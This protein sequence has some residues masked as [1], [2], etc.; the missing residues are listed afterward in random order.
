MRSFVKLRS[1]SRNISGGSDNSGT[2][3]C[4]S[5]SMMRRSTDDDGY[6]LDDDVDDGEQGV[7]LMRQMNFL[8]PYI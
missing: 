1:T 7:H 6:P 4:T 5:N 2:S 3:Y 8:N